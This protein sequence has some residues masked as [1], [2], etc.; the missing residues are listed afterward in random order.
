MNSRPV[1]FLVIGAVVVV[2]VVAYGLWLGDHREVSFVSGASHPYDVEVDGQ[3]FT[4]RP[5]ARDVR[6]VGLGVHAVKVFGPTGVATEASFDNSAGVFG[7]VFESGK[8]QVFNPDGVAV[9]TSE[10]TEYTTRD[11][12]T[13]AYSWDVL[14]NFTFLSERYDFAFQEFPETQQIKSNSVT[15]TRIN[16]D[17]DARYLGAEWIKSKRGPDAA[18]AWLK[19]RLTFDPYDGFASDALVEAAPTPETLA[20]LFR[21][22][23]GK[24]LRIE[25]LLS[26]RGLAEHLGADLDPDRK[27]LVAVARGSGDVC[28]GYAIYQLLDGADAE[29][30]LASAVDCPWANGE[31]AVRAVV[32][33]DVAKAKELAAKLSPTRETSGLAE[34]WKAA[35]LATGDVEAVAAWERANETSRWATAIAAINAALRQRDAAKANAVRDAYLAQMGKDGETQASIDEVS[36]GL[37]AAIAYGNRDVAGVKAAHDEH[38]AAIGVEVA[39]VEGNFD[40]AEFGEAGVGEAALMA[41][42]ALRHKLPQAPVMLKAI[43]DELSDRHVGR[44][45]SS[46]PTLADVRAAGIPLETL[47]GILALLAERYPKSDLATEADRLAFEERSPALFLAT[48]PGRH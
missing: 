15:R 29:E 19:N 40:V 10:S 8:T 30:G 3:R 47:R 13:A 39:L 26:W 21:L 4:L 37:A 17:K 41:A 20:F 18:I 25:V 2:G 16:L 6:E 35:M 24:P 38:D 9:L 43:D 1:L 46:Q 48:R 33:G 12:N 32:A 45:I 36:A 7:A 27:I 5:G 34:S 22:I 31:R 28:A 42:S 23:D 11:V 44:W 14:T